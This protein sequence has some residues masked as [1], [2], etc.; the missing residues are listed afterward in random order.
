M[1]RTITSLERSYV[2]ALRAGHLTLISPMGSDRLEAGRHSVFRTAPALTIPTLERPQMARR[3]N[4]TPAQIEEIVAAYL[5]GEGPSATARQY[6]TGV[7]S[8][9]SYL[10][11]RGIA[12]R[13]HPARAYDYDRRFFAILDTEAK[14][15]WAGFLLADGSVSEFGAVRL[16]L[17][18]KDRS[19]LDAFASA[20]G[21]GLPIAEEIKKD[22][23]RLPSVR[24]SSR[25]M[26]H[27]L[28]RYG[29]I[30]RKTFGH[31]IPTGIPPEMVRHFLR[32]YFDGDGC[33]TEKSQSDC[34]ILQYGLAV[35]GS[36]EFLEWF[37]EQA[38]SVIPA[39]VGNLR[40][41]RGTWM[42][43][44]GGNRKA[45]ALARWLYEGATVSLE[46]KAV[47]ARR[48]MAP[49]RVRAL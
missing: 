29:I 30:P 38:R 20:I 12:K 41:L 42:L 49:G 21:G 5:G 6:N 31:P 8:V 43:T 35:C 9:Y 48:A 27:D 37:R 44:V 14:A 28:S 13:F 25:E 47:R 11:A 40:E 1:A 2:G 7:T 18:A 46:R 23:R 10:R 33:I 24:F 39:L 32:G 16:K 15:Y 19:H 3:Q 45:G 17:G 34:G 36:R 26:V 4:N 22:G